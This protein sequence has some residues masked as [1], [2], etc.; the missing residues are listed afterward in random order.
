MERAQ[1]SQSLPAAVLDDEALRRR[2]VGFAA[3][4]QRQ[5]GVQLDASKTRNNDS[6]VRP[7]EHGRDPLGAE[8]RVVRLHERAGVEEV[9][10]RFQN[11]PARSAAIASDQELGSTAVIR[12]T[13][14]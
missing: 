8:F 10:H 13:S 4:F 2:I 5:C 3:R 11:R 9:V 1:G 7:A 6:T 14:S 12:R